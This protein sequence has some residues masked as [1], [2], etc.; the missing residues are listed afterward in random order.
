MSTLFNGHPA[1]IQG[2][3]TFLPAGYR[4]ECG[5][6][7]NPDAIR[8]TTPSGTNTIS[9]QA[10]G[11]ASFE[12]VAPA[13][14]PSGQPH[15]A[16][17]A[18][19][20]DEPRPAWQQQPQAHNQ[21]PSQQTSMV[22]SGTPYSPKGRVMQTPIY[23]QQGAQSHQ[24]EG[25][26]DY[27]NQHEQQSA[28]LTHQ[29]EQQQRGVTQLQ[30]AASATAGGPGR[31]AM[32]SEPQMQTPSAAQSIGSL[33]GLGM[34]ASQGDASKRGPVE[35]NHAISYVNKIKVS[36]S[37]SFRTLYF[38]GT[39]TDEF[40]FFFFHRIV[41]P[42]PPIFTSNF[43]RSSKRIKGNLNLFKMSIPKSRSC[44]VARRTCCKISSSSFPN[45]LH[46][47]KRKL[48]PPIA[49]RRMKPPP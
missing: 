32:R 9:M 41:L 24:Q 17:T 36:D 30:N 6:E 2:F 45:Q 31:S 46:K 21:Q 44:S 20:Y 25:G 18:E 33:A 27:H 5:T 3:N 12:P 19:Y 48:R 49:R 11:H 1:L 39:P 15:P 7:D 8:V 29:Q 10:S 38:L 22:G 13:G 26:Y 43:W 40:F 42:I 37:L 34:Q 47:P 14:Q 35:F 16:R 23:G 4:I 28:A